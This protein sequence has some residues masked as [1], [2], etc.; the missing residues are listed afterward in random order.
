VANVA[1]RKRL[2]RLEKLAGGI[3]DGRCEQCRDVAPVPL[4]I[5]GQDGPAPKFTCTYC[6]WCN[7]TQGP[8]APM[9]IWLRPENGGK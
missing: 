1:L 4:V 5:S 9:R 7:Y 3:P 2:R 8:N 6:G